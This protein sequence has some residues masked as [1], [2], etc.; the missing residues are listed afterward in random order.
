MAIIEIKGRFLNC[1]SH[2]SIEGKKGSLFIKR[3]DALAS[4]AFSWMLIGYNYDDSLVSS[5]L[6]SDIVPS[7]RENLSID[8]LASGKIWRIRGISEGKYLAFEVRRSEIDTVEYP[9]D[10]E[11]SDH[12]TEALNELF[13]SE[14][15]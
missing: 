2:K 14:S 10:G 1:E 15:E 4:K 13:N 5:L 12:I 8:F 9:T 7:E 6:V 11:L 3:Y